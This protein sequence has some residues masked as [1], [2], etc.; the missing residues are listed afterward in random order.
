MI[1]L[2]NKCTQYPCRI[3]WLPSILLLCEK[4]YKKYYL[5]LNVVEPVVKF[6]KYSYVD[7]VIIVM[8][9]IPMKW[10]KNGDEKMLKFICFFFL[11]TFMGADLKF[12][13]ICFFS[14]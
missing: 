4:N 7:F 8:E 6:Y 11:S 12:Q 10:G 3:F 13:L 5:I 14:N 9:V 1:N 2:I